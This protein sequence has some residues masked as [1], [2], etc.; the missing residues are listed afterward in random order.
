[1]FLYY[2]ERKSWVWVNSVFIV[3]LIDTS[4]LEFSRKLNIF[5]FLKEDRYQQKLSFSLTIG[6]KSTSGCISKKF[7]VVLWFGTE[8][9]ILQSTLNLNEIAR[10]LKYLHEKKIVQKVGHLIFHSLLMSS[11]C[12]CEVL[13]LRRQKISLIKD[14]NFS[15]NL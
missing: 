2:S 13:V 11:Y 8:W 5:R 4:K 15:Y 3:Q 10:S 6:L 1:M 12:K 14:C 9:D 7:P